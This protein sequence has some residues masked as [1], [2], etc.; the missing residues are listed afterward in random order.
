MINKFYYELPQKFY[1]FYKK[2]PTPAY[3]PFYEKLEEISLRVFESRIEQQW[4][5]VVPYEDTLANMKHE[6]MEN[7]LLSGRLLSG[8]PNS[9]WWIVLVSFGAA[10]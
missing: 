3:S 7:E 1:T 9:W 6:Y 4:S 8:I 2:F 10:A 5:D